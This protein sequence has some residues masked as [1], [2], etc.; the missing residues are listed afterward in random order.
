MQPIR[1]RA[2]LVIDTSELP[3][4]QL[5][6]DLR[7]YL[8][9][10]ATGEDFQLVVMSFGYKYGIPLDADIVFDVRFLPNPF[11]VNGLKELTGLDRRVADY[12]LNKPETRRFVDDFEGMLETLLPL[13]VKEGKS[14]LTLA[15]GCTGGKH[16]AVAISEV[17]AQ[18]L[19]GLGFNVH[20]RHRDMGRE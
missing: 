19:R 1:E 20:M 12:V 15:I 6:S 11:W 16:R 14:F 8:A 10:S 3:M 18:H 13:Y 9:D 2:D 5:R 17:L 7:Q 4:N